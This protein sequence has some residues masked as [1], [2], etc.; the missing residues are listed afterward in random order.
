MKWK[1]DHEKSVLVSNF[2]RRGW[3][4]A[5]DEGEW[6]IYFASPQTIKT[7]FSSESSVRLN[8]TQLVS[9]FPNHFELTRKDLMVKNIKRYKKEFERLLQMERAAEPSSA[10]PAAA[11]ASSA[12]SAFGSSLHGSG[13]SVHSGGSSLHGGEDTIDIIPSTFILPGDF[14]LFVEEYR[15]SPALTWI[16][17]PSS[18][19][20]GKGIFLVN[21]LAQV[22]RWFHSRATQMGP[23]DAYVISRY[24]DDPLLIGGKKFDLRLYVLVTSYRPLKA[25]IFRRG[26]A[27]FTTINYT[28]EI[29][30]LD[31]ELIH[32]T[33]VAVQK[34]SDDYSAQHGGKWS[35]QNLRLYIESTR[36][37]E[38]AEKLFRDIGW[39]V[40]HSLKAC[41]HVIINDKHC[42]ECY[43]YDILIDSQL[44]PWL[45]EVNAS[46]SLSS[47]TP[48]DRQL[49]TQLLS[50]VLDLVV[51]PGFL[52]PRDAAARA[53]QQQPAA[54]AKRRPAATM[55][56]ELDDSS[57]AK[58]P[59]Q[60]EL[61]YDESLELEAERARRQLEEKRRASVTRPFR[62]GGS[63]P[64]AH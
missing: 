42:F 34:H 38:A 4:R 64:W 12:G 43:G 35:L 5:T 25:Y 47:T 3:T 39:A 27:R 53:S 56:A 19:S 63:G 17:K 24:V 49:K 48:D 36:G 57:R 20:Q 50:E 15:R 16:M 13:S 41:Q 30:E 1:A 46:P 7:L 58:R 52:E 14:S 29:T 8:D 62:M 51:P 59:Q 9:H 10:A 18:R 31:N 37:L 44:K 21:K 22:K 61:L 33:N 6:N 26:F 28:N 55:D 45:I 40:V 23:K 2:E 60:F 32:L 11:A 54:A